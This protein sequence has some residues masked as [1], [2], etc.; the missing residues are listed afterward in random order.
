MQGIATGHLVL[1]SKREM[2][3]DKLSAGG[4]GND[5][6][7][8]VTTSVWASSSWWSG[9]GRENPIALQPFLL[10]KDGVNDLLNSLCC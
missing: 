8:S 10:P 1:F 4:T 6:R 5:I 2:F 9:G 7:P 3:S